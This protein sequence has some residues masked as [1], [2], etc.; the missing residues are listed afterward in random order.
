MRSIALVFSAALLLPSSTNAAKTTECSATSGERKVALLE[1]YTSEGC[2]SCPTADEW[3]RALPGRG[4]TPDRL[5][6]LALHVDY[7]NYLGWEDPFAQPKFTQRQRRAGAINRL[8][9]IYTPQLILNGKDFRSW[10]RWE[11]VM[12]EINRINATRPRAH[13]QFALRYEKPDRLHISGRAFVPDAI[14]RRNADA[15]V[16]I[17]ES[18]LSRAVRAGEN[19]GRTLHHDFVAREFIGPLRT[20]SETGTLLQQQLRLRKDWQAEKLGVVVFVQDRRS[21]DILQ[22]LAMPLC[23]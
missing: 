16:V 2:S 11:R 7:W 18:G 5:I 1:L 14:D 23:V 20:T 13:V 9:T 17:Y 4:L 15:Y 22:A 21:G 6:P 12:Q 19:A 10:V 3:L 8:P